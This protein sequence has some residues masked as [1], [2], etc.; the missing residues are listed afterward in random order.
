MSAADNLA[1]KLSRGAIEEA[2]AVIQAL[3]PTEPDLGAISTALEA[4]PIQSSAPDRMALAWR[5][6]Y[7]SIH[8]LPRRVVLVGSIDDAPDLAG[9]ADDAAGLLVVE[10]DT[11]IVSTAEWL[12]RG[13]QWRSLSE[14]GTDLNAGERLI[15]TSALINSL[16][17]AAV[18]VLG[19]LAG[20]NMLA[21]HGGALRSNTAL[22]AALASS[23][24]LS[25][26]DLLRE[27]LRSCLPS[28][29]A[30]YGPDARAARRIADLFGLEPDHFSKF[31]DLRDWRDTHGFLSTL[32][33]G[34]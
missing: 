19:S 5:G 15:L 18:L 11:K 27:Y 22:F 16:Q 30:L 23:P 4:A 12:P 34:K 26:S 21:W 3:C 1:W 10:T 31:R 13:T 33:T 24:E 2:E 17:P 8:E 7:L 6:L 32:G 25:A 20:W 9:L 14:F 28:L 29:S